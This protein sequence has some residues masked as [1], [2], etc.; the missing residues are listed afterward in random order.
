MKRASSLRRSPFL[1]LLAA[2]LVGLGVFLAHEARPAAAHHVGSYETI[3]SATLNPVTVFSGASGCDTGQGQASERCTAPGRLSDTTVSYDGNSYTIYAIVADDDGGDLTLDLTSGERAS[4]LIDFA[5]RVGN[6]SLAFADASFDTARATWSGTGISWSSGAPVELSLF[7]EVPPAASPEGLVDHLPVWS[8]TLTDP[9][10]SGMGCVEADGGAAR[11][12]EHLSGNRYFGPRGRGSYSGNSFN[13]YEGTY[14]VDQLWVY[15]NG[16]LQLTLDQAIPA[17]HRR[18]LT[19]IVQGQRFHAEDNTQTSGASLIW[20]NA[21]LSWN[22]GDRVWVGAGVRHEPGCAGRPDASLNPTDLRAFPGGRLLTLGWVNPRTDGVVE[23]VVRW[24]KSGTTPWLNLHGALG[25]WF[26]TPTNYTHDI[27]GLDGG[28]A[29][30]AQVRIVHQGGCSQWVSVAGTPQVPS[31]S[32]FWGPSLLTVQDLGADGLGCDNF[33]STASDRCSDTSTLSFNHFSYG[34]ARYEIERLALKDGALV[35]DFSRH[36][37]DEA[38]LDNLNLLTGG[39]R[40]PFSSAR[41]DRYNNKRLI[42][43]NTG[44]SWSAGDVVG[45]VLEGGKLPTEL[46]V[47]SS[48]GAL[49]EGGPA[50]NVYLTLDQ[51]AP[52]AATASIGAHVAGGG[53]TLETR[54][55]MLGFP[56]FALGAKTAVLALRVPDDADD[57]NCR[58]AAYG[59]TFGRQYLGNT[60][61]Q[62]FAFTV[63]DDDGAADDCTGLLGSAY[64]ST[65]T[66]AVSRVHQVEGEDGIRVEVLASLD[67]P[68]VFR[69]F[70]NVEVSGT[71]ARLTQALADD[72]AW[73]RTTT[74]GGDFVINNTGLVIHR[75][76]QKP[77]SEYSIGDDNSA[78]HDVLTEVKILP[79]ADDDETIIL[80]ARIDDHSWLSSNTLTLNVGALRARLAGGGSGQGESGQGGPPCEGCGTAGDLGVL[81]QGQSPYA[82]LLAQ[83]KEW[84]NDPLWAHAKPHTDRW[85]RALL[86]FGEPVSDPSLTEMTA[87]EAQ[88]FADRGWERWVEVAAALRAIEA[89]AQRPA[90]QLNVEPDQQVDPA[91]QVVGAQQHQEPPNQA[92]VVSSALADVSGLEIGATQ[93]VSLSGVFDDADGDALSFS[94]TSDDES[95]ATVSVAPD[96]S[97]LTLSGIAAGTATITVTAED[98]GGNRVSDTFDV[99]VAAPQ[100]QSK[101]TGAA[102]RYDANNNGVI[103]VSEYIQAR[104][105]YAYGRISDAE[106]QQVLDAWLASQ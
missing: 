35:I 91:P 15:D 65:L 30:E 64:A 29:Y 27:T 106:W 85:D 73:P 12:S 99:T 89:A 28:A 60:V 86:A 87:A 94:A 82:A 21:G 9:D 68:A 6:S 13:I 49:R 100:P 23:H 103:D 95:V 54:Y 1:L 92:P 11:C 67:R 81:G 32:I 47:T 26:K 39:M 45:L 104:R 79:N 96:G 7:R 77:T 46:T 84:R 80:S 50:V 8:A 69:R 78:E 102:G 40:H 71:A 33:S 36:I 38:F 3:W 90:D 31:N 97:A 75:G 66:L 16:S 4:D 58:P 72:Y 70:V 55:W 74:S 20:P 83:M 34:Y 101:L 41:R 61:A 10:E 59:A 19:F 25:D 44:L 48:G 52:S 63:V 76:K 105:D 2:A 17:R 98:A 57:N 37:S 56:E 93:D 14:R 42:L 62:D 24:R 51:Q 18:L 5:L 53:D 88:G 43:D 22:D